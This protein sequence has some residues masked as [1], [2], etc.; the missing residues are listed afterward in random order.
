MPNAPA[1]ACQKGHG[2]YLVECRSDLVMDA[3]KQP[4]VP[5]IGAMRYGAIITEIRAYRLC[6]GL[7]LLTLE[8]DPTA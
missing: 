4:N 5:R 7:Y 3:F 6:K 1:I 8:V 2:Q